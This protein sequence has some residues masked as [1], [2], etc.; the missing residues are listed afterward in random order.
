MNLLTKMTA[1]ELRKN[2]FA[3]WQ[4]DSIKEENDYL[5]LSFKHFKRDYDFNKMMMVILKP[6]VALIRIEHAFYL[7]LQGDSTLEI[8]KNLSGFSSQAMDNFIKLIEFF[9]EQYGISEETKSPLEYV[10]RE[11]IKNALE[12]SLSY[13]EPNFELRPR[14]TQ[15]EEHRL[16]LIEKFK[17]LEKENP[18]IMKFYISLGPRFNA[19]GQK[20]PHV[21]F[22]IISP[23]MNEL[24]HQRLNQKINKYEEYKKAG[25]DFNDYLAEEYVLEVEAQYAHGLGTISLLNIVDHYWKGRAR[26]EFNIDEKKTQIGLAI[27]VR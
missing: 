27:E 2:P 22:F 24:N 16:L 23:P 3:T 11:L 18:N 14:E 21:T 13:H 20:T 4:Y 15:K 9:E 12:G 17:K 8:Q 5:R 7:G 26:V 6:E 19:A 10:L 25:K 1:E